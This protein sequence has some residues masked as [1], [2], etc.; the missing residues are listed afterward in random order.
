[1]KDE[2][3]RL[4]P[5]RIRQIPIGSN[6]QA[7]TPGPAAVAAA[8]ARLG[9]TPDHFLLGYFGFLS[10]SKGA[11]TLLH[12]LAQLDQ[13]VH[14]AFIGGRLGS[15]DPDNNQVFLAHLDALIEELGLRERVHWTGF[16][17]DGDVSTYLHA[18]DLMVMPY[19]DGV[20]LRRGTLM[21]V[22]AHDRP[23][24]T[25]HPT[26]PTPELIHGQNVW[27]TP[28]DDVPELTQAIGHLA[29]VP[30]VR[31]Q[32]GEAARQVAELFTWDKIAAKT[33]AFF[34]ELLNV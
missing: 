25:T 9:L 27:L 24:V 8:R 13:Q 32:L 21:A 18:A 34:Q 16:V 33:A 7:L 31:A 26:V 10:E 17:A 28:V 4:H 2:S 15:S 3:F 5:S 14:L 23:L 12:A 29:A 20:S 6:I 19:R 22:L 1:M 30:A 11:D